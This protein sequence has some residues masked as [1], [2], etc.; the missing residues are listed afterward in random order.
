[1]LTRLVLATGAILAAATMAVPLTLLGM[2]NTLTGSDSGAPGGGSAS[3]GL[4]G[5]SS[6]A[7]GVTTYVEGSGVAAGPVAT[8][9]LEYALARI[10]TRYVWGGTGVDGFD[11]SGLVMVAYADA[12][13]SIPRTAQQQFDAG[14]MV[15]PDTQLLPGDLV[16][17]G[18]GVS[19]ITHV[20]MFIGISNHQAQMVDAPHPGADVRVEPFPDTPGVLWGSEAYIGATRPAD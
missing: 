20:G 9:A 5:S 3:T 1:M 11:C 19:A 14:P 4:D 18:S 13:V 17:F 16:Y 6:S 12:G 7:G 8:P 10:G 15:P 2:V